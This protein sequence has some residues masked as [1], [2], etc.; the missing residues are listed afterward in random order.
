MEKQFNTKD[1]I[2]FGNFI[3]DN[4]YT[5]GS[6]KYHPYSPIFESG[7]IEHVFITWLIQTDRKL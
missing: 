4:F 2:E 1:L 5:D 6:P 7:D 3:R